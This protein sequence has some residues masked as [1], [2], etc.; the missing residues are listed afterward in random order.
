MRRARRS[1]NAAYALP[2]G[3][4]SY[5]PGAWF[6]FPYNGKH[7]VHYRTF[8]VS[9]YGTV[10]SFCNRL[11]KVYPGGKRYAV[12]NGSEFNHGIADDLHLFSAVSGAFAVNGK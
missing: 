8:L 3:H 12:K 2:G 1:M 11:R 10:C 7:V 4:L 5:C 9:L 6:S